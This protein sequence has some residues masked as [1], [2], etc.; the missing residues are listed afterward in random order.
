MVTVT[1]LFCVLAT[2]TTP[3]P[4]KLKLRTAVVSVVP[5]SATAIGNAPA[6]AG[7]TEPPATGGVTVVAATVTVALDGVTPP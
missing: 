5:S 6:G 4:T 1:A 2:A 7:I 3:S